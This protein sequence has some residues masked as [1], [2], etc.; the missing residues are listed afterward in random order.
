MLKR[1]VIATAL[2][3]LTVPAPAQKGDEL[4]RAVRD[5]GNGLVNEIVRGGTGEDRLLMLGLQGG[6]V[7]MTGLAVAPATQ[8]PRPPQGTRAILRTRAATANGNRGPD[9]ADLAFVRRTGI[10]VFIAGAWTEP[11]PIWEVARINGEVRVR[12]IDRDAEPGPWQIPP[13]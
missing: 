13:P 12:E 8:W 5:F 3:L 10:R 1:M 11:P 2:L 4:L 7:V 6:R 9:P